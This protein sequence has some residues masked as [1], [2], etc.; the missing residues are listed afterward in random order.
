MTDCDKKLT[1]EEKE[2]ALLRNAVDS[3]E[4]K[5]GE[6]VAQSPDIISIIK[7]LEEFLKKKKLVCYGGTAINNI[8][9]KEAQFY[10]KDIE[11]PDY[12][13]YSPNAM[14]DAKELADIYAK[15]GYSEVETRS[16]MHLGTYKVFVN[17]IPIA[18]VTQIGK[19]VFKVLN[20]TAIVINDI[21]YAH[22]DYLRLQIYKELS[23]PE[24]DISRWEKI[25]KRLILLHKHFPLKN[26][27]KCSQVNFMRDFNGNAELANTLYNIVKDTI[28]DEGF[29][30]IGGYASSLYSRYMP[31]DKK[32]QLKEVPDFDVLA[33][34]PLKAANIIKDSLQKA[35]ITHIKINKKA[36]AGNEMIL[37]HY[38]ITVDGDTLCF[39]YQP[40]GCVSYNEIKI[41]N[42][43]VKVATIE[44]MLL[45]LLAFLY[46]DRPYYDHQRIICMAQY[47]INVQAKNRLKQ[48]GLLKRFNLNCYGHE[49]TLTEIKINRSDMFK[50][51]RK[52]RKSPEYEKYFLKY[53]PE[54]IGVGPVKEKKEGDEDVLAASG[55]AKKAMN[56]KK[57]SMNITKKNKNKTRAKPRRKI[58]TKKNANLNIL[59]K[60]INWQKI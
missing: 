5:I 31:E 41:N 57:S 49:K 29:V 33:E 55:S 14:K 2:L 8:L 42:K 27:P 45:F 56:I 46:S 44:T 28:I 15:H 36:E 58:A 39:I 21:Y 47:L 11:I 52:D 48:K 18:D 23:R 30:F 32:N 51:L 35:G 24:A 9:P 38:E 4:T 22:P 13:F 10:N 54:I 53:T 6:K 40:P 25:Y 26:N 43:M 3:F 17:F 19:N 12:D 37:E 1:F 34:D 7:I 20:E 59:D 60:L 50:K 16:G